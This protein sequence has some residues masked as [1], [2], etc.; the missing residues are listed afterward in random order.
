MRQTLRRPRHFASCPSL[1]RKDGRISE[2]G[3]DL[4]PLVIFDDKS[5]VKRVL[6]CCNVGYVAKVLDGAYVNVKTRLWRTTGG[7]SV[8]SDM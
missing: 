1:L 4:L 2:V 5:A 7:A 3:F 6:A 8:S